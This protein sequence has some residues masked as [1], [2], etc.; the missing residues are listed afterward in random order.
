MTDGNSI[1]FFNIIIENH[2]TSAFRLKILSPFFILNVPLIRNNHF[3][4][5]DLI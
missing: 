3:G 1:E 5:E 2:F 4:F